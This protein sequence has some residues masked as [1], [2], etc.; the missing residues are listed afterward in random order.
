MNTHFVV[1]IGRR[2][3]L[4]LDGLKPIM[5]S[6]ISVATRFDRF[7]V[8]RNTIEQAAKEGKYDIGST[9]NSRGRESKCFSPAGWTPTPRSRSSTYEVEV[10]GLPTKEV[11]KVAAK[12]QEWMEDN[13]ITASSV[14]VERKAS[15]G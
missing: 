13:H 10:D 15:L 14:Y 4:R 6:R 3:Y 2:S 1:R 11:A 5:V 7:Q 9:T 12:L 8:I